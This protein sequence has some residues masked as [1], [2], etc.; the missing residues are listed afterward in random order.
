MG[1]AAGLQA[2]PI[3]TLSQLAGSGS[4]VRMDALYTG[5]DLLENR[6]LP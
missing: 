5:E 4:M 6:S 3:Y 1:D 2:F